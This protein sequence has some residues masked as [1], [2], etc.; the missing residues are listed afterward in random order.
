VGPTRSKFSRE[1]ESKYRLSNAKYQKHCTMCLKVIKDLIGLSSILIDRVFVRA[2]R[3]F[4]ACSYAFPKT[5]LVKLVG[6]E[7]A[8]NHSCP[9]VYKKKLC[10]LDY[11]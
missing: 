3:L 2:L 5:Y 6:R 4:P 11:V 9:I 8:M 7:I 1:I 10:A